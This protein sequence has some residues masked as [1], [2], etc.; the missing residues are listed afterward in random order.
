M[1]IQP[2]DILE[3]GMQNMCDSCPDMTVL[4]GKLVWSCRMEEPLRYGR[5]AHTVPKERVEI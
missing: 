2:P 4:D 1:I 5:F 3:D